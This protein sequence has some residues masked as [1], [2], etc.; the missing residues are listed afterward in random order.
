[1]AVQSILRSRSG[2]YARTSFFVCV[3]VVLTYLAAV[4]E[5]AGATVLQQARG[6]A[7]EVVGKGCFS[8]MH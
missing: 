3:V 6:E 5:E 7:R 4:M 2:G 1:M 8:Y